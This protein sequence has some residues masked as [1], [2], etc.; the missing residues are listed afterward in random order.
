MTRRE[1][2]AVVIG[3]GPS[4]CATAL[5]LA[6]TGQRVL[7]LEAK[8]AAVDRLAGEWLHPRA[9]QHALEL[10]VDLAAAVSHPSGR[11]FV[12]HPDDGSSPIVLPYPAG[13]LGLS[14]EHGILVETLRAHCQ[15]RDGV[16]WEPHA[17]ALRIE[18]QTVTYERR[19]PGGR[20]VT[21]CVIADLVVGA[22]GRSG[23]L[24][25]SHA[26]S[27]IGEARAGTSSRIAGY[28]LERCELPFEGFFHVIL[29]GPGPA[30]AI[31]LDQGRV[32]LLLDVPPSLAIPRDGGVSLYEAWAPAM[33]EPMRAA[34][35]RAAH[36]GPPL[37]APIELRPRE[38]FGREGLALVG[39]AVGCHHPLTASGLTFAFE[40]ATTLADADKI[41][42]WRRDR[43]REGRVPE[44][45][46]VGLYEVFADDSAE[47]VT[48]RRAVY[49][50]WRNHPSER[51]RAMGFLSGDDTSAP[52]FGVSFLRA[53]GR[54]G[55]EIAKRALE[56]GRI[57]GGAHTSLDLAQRLGWMLGGT[58]HLSN[59]LPASLRERLRGPKTAEERYG[60]ALRAS[61]PRAEVVGLGKRSTPASEPDARAA[62]ERATLALLA[63]Q[64]SDGSFEGEVVWCPMLAA[65]YVLAMHA[66]GRPLSE[67]RRR[68]VL[69]HFERTQL[70]TPGAQGLWGLHEK[71]DPF[72]FVTILVYVAS[73][74]LGLSKDDP[75]LADAHAFIRRE[76]GATAIPSWGKLWLALVSLYDWRGVSPVLPEVW[77]APRWMPIHPSRYYCHTRNIY[78]GMA[79]LYGER[80]SAAASPTILAVRDELFVEGWQQVDWNKAR[81]T[82]REGDVHVAP[83][84]ALELTYDALAL[85]DRTRTRAH[86]APILAEL[87]EHIRYELRST[88]HT[89]IS[90]VSG[91]LDILALHV[92]D[93]QDPDVAEAMNRFEGWIWED[94]EDGARVCGARSATWDTSFAA[95][96]LAAAYPA[97]RGESK[98]R[99]RAGLQSADAFLASQQIM[100]GTGRESEFYRI[101]PSGGYCFA[102]VWHGWPVSDCTAEAMVARIES[103]FG[104]ADPAALEA[105]ARF[106]LRCKNTD[107]GYGSYEARR[108]DVPLEWLNPS[109]MFGACMTEKSYVECTASCL[110]ALALYRKHLRGG[111]LGDQIDA[112]LAQGRELLTR[113]QNADGSWAGVW[114]V[115]FVYG[116]L[117]GMRGLLA[118]G[119]PTT[120]PRIRRAASFLRAHQRADGGWGEHHQ[121]VFT[122]HWVEHEEG[123][124]VQTAWALMALLESRDADFDCMERA[125]RFLAS[126]QRDDG[127]WAKQDPEGVFFHTALLDYVLY[128]AYFPVWSLGL[129]EARRAEREA[130]LGEFAPDQSGHA[131]V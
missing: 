1:H 94:E 56:S 9:V 10:G 75:L 62:L 38:D 70:S 99:A 46:A 107:G 50:L 55:A 77:R 23:Q 17:R 51:L 91:L 14:M 59:V 8:P 47:T 53:M 104:Q 67:T 71:S 81:K 84:A 37:W 7:V 120:D 60:A 65:Q 96:A 35:A 31:R 108:V 54:S 20:S 103:P 119:V 111:E 72:L 2:D 131:S 33:P 130:L 64:E 48:L 116:T 106:V 74:L 88:S 39:D 115:N 95:Q 97:L 43:I 3:A 82:R 27:R 22:S 110:A 118:T 128:R 87:R 73:R 36:A 76:G 24:D 68:L 12:V 25:S 121:S 79:T 52:R 109:E 66:M 113:L 126:K 41:A 125:A 61:A 85:L 93:A 5:A 57:K 78:M 44:M 86:R 63:E 11:G 32:R 30:M 29:G 19:L 13:R 83:S 112:A 98:S 80:F 26:E 102:G 124:V 101:D 40:D 18:G 89:C 58:M 21:K 34:F 100:H 117:F 45:I 42:T 28:V 123:Q 16:T 4:G 114:G 105:A 92:A 49:D 90:P 122:Q 6:R 129:F 127:T 15:R 69:K